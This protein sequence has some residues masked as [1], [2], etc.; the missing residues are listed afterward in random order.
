MK[1]IIAVLLCSFLALS[2]PGCGKKGETVKRAEELI[3]VKAVSVGL[4][5][6]DKSLEYVGDIKG[7]DEAMVYPKVS[8][9]IIEK[10]KEDGSPVKKGEVI[11]YIDR[12]EVGLK[13]EKAP[14]ESP[15]D[16]FVG[17]VYVDIGSFV[18]TQTAVALVTDIRK[19]EISL[20]IPEQYTTKISIGQLAEIM[21][22]TYPD[23][24]FM[25][26][27]VQ[28]SPVVTLSTR[29]API[30]IEVDNIEHSLQ[31]GMFASVK[32]IIDSKKNVPVVPKEAV[33]G[34]AP[35]TFVYVIRGERAVLQ[36]VVL[37]M[38]QG[39]VYEIRSGVK[40]DDLVVIMGQQRLVDGSRVTVETDTD[41]TV[42]Q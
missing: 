10:V 39:P 40:K 37:G 32:L 26:K 25:G 16:G 4:Q 42:K 14:V 7:Q 28:I 6:I 38:K 30:K 18:S 17:R 2:L 31:S 9:K 41:D 20:E 3:P 19:I 35:E 13:F 34:R 15:L 33:M 5:D 36:K 24:K 23:K 22:D 29:T 1:K 27:V 21:V 8:G 11:A 12:D